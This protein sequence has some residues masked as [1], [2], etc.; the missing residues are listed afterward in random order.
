LGK[1]CEGV[2]AGVRGVV[3]EGSF[4]RGGGWWVRKRGELRWAKWVAVVV[5]EEEKRGKTGM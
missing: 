4:E 5:F 2:G 3:K 1:R